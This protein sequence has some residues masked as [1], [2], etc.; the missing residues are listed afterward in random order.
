MV[1]QKFVCLRNGNSCKSIVWFYSLG[2]NNVRIWVVLPRTGKMSNICHNFFFLELYC[3]QTVW[4]FEI[5]STVLKRFCITFAYQYI[6]I[7]CF[8]AHTWQ[9]WQVGHRLQLSAE[10]FI[11][12]SRWEL[13]LLLLYQPVSGITWHGHHNR[14]AQDV[15]L[16]MRIIQPFNLC[17]SRLVGNNRA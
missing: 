6:S 15:I 17:I 11:A 12:E 16:E 2:C 9:H 1:L 10:L 3:G 13:E 5:S 8:F 4:F 14:Q 7:C